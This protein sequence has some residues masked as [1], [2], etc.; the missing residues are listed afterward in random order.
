MIASKFT[1]EGTEVIVE[2][3]GAHTIVMVHGWPDTHRVWDGAVKALQ[4]Q[5]RCVRFTFPGFGAEPARP[6]RSLDDLTRLLLA[7]VDQASPDQP[8]TLLLHDWGCFFGYEL[9]SRHPD[10][11]ARVVGLDIGDT[12][13]PAYLRSLT[14]AHKAMILVYQ[15]WLATA[16]VLGRFVNAALGNGLTR[17]MARGMRCPAASAD[18][19]WAMNFPYA[20]AWFELAGG[21]Q[22]AT[23][24]T[25][26]CPML[27]VYGKS[28][29]FMF[30][31]REWVDSLNARTGSQAVGL[32]CGHWLMLDRASEF[33]ELLTGWLH[34]GSAT[35][36]P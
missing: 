1:V 35:M 3:Q 12:S 20:M 14:L 22:K 13:S 34:S 8:V 5:Y 33:E 30:H 18:I 25:P 24:F 10:R 26:H 9:A 23:P 6:A 4:G 16:W 31:S 11:I 19:H 36:E 17:F 21:L 2:G 29:P 15:L 28:K 32:P 27:F 7:I